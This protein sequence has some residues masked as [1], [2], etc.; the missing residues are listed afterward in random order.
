MSNLEKMVDIFSDQY[1]FPLLQG[2]LFV[3][4]VLSLVIEF[5]AQ[6]RAGFGG[7]SLVVTRSQTSMNIYYGTYAALSGILVALCLTVEFAKNHRVLWVLVDTL[8]SSYLCLLNPWFRLKL[9][10]FSAFL[11]K[12]EA[13]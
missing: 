2:V 13:R 6:K 4:L 1:M 5:L 11:T 12:V 7:K 3:V 8:I 10:D 9:Q